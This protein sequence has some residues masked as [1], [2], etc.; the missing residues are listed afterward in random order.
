MR[1]DANQ[2]EIAARA[3]RIDRAV[4]HLHFTRGVGE[5]AIFFVGRCRGQNH[6]GTLRG[7]REEHFVDDEQFEPGELVRLG[8]AESFY[9]IGA[10]DVQGF[11]FSGR[12]GFHHLA[13]RQTRRPWEVR[14]RP[15]FFRS[16]RARMRR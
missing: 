5:R 2:I 8:D 16:G 4:G 10:D 13:R 14:R 15:R 3:L 7:F 12:G 6:V 11:K 9:G 1:K